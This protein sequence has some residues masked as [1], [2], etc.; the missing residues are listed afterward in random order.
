MFKIVLFFGL[1]V[2][3]L[4][5]IWTKQQ[6]EHHQSP[7]QVGSNLFIACRKDL[8]PEDRDYAS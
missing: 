8:V 6:V 4:I 3:I 5:R 1:K 7:L 2:M